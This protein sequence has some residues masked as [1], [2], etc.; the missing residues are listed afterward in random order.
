MDGTSASPGFESRVRASARRG[1]SIGVWERLAHV[2]LAMACLAVLWVGR[3]LEPSPAGHGSHVQLGMPPCA[4]VV[5]FDRPCP[6]CGM[7]TSVA[8]A[9]RG[10]F[11]RSLVVQ[12]AGAAFALFCAVAFWGSLYIAATGSAL[13]RLVGLRLLGTRSLWCAGALVGVSWAYKFVT[14]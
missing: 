3:G 4:W 13:G 8:H 6:T 5:R 10:E 14:W 11:L 12:P 7:T 2:A 1:P 9:A